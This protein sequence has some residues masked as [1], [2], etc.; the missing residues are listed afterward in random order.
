MSSPFN[1]PFDN[2]FNTPFGVP[3]APP[4]LGELLPA[5]GCPL[6]DH[7]SFK[8]MDN[9]VS[10]PS[11]ACWQNYGQII[12]L[13]EKTSNYGIVNIA[14][15]PDTYHSEAAIIEC[16]YLFNPP[17]TTNWCLPICKFIDENNLLGVRLNNNEIQVEQRHGGTWTT[18][19][20]AP[21]QLGRFRVI[22][23][24][25]TISIAVDDV[26]IIATTHSIA[27]A[28]Y[29]G[30][31]LHQWPVSGETPIV[32]N[33]AIQLLSETT[34]PC[35]SASNKPYGIA[36][37]EHYWD[38][39]YQ[40]WEG[41]NCHANNTRDCWCSGNPAELD[42]PPDSAWI[43]WFCPECEP[44]IPT[45]F[46]L[47]PRAGM[48]TNWWLDNNPKG[49]VF[50]G[51]RR[52]ETLV[53]LWRKE[54]IADWANGNSR[55]WTITGGTEAFYGYRLDIIRTNAHDGGGDFSVCIGDLRVWGTPAQNP[56]PDNVVRYNDAILTKDG[57]YVTYN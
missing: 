8:V 41:M 11:W 5:D 55:E 34:S 18:L 13:T 24:S 16:D 19:A 21:A 29:Y 38:S 52:D 48:P 25:A 45:R 44:M 42:P 4:F 36:A 54:D 28:G 50:Y 6:E 53:E 56:Y 12:S 9:E 30:L 22:I 7:P 27:E 23:N 49:M 14:Y 46:R 47:T 2:P 32:S 40:P 35:M 31:S 17:G 57:E 26:D 3:F 33:Y 39:D 51:I 20:T 1:T 37:A 15:K 10:L 43:Q